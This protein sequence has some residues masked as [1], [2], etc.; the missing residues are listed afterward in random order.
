MTIDVE[1]LRA[2]GLAFYAKCRTCLFV[3]E[4]YGDAASAGVLGAVH[5]CD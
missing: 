2:G 3:S 4:P 1:P 5:R